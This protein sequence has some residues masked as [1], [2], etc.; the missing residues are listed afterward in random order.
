MLRTRTTEP[1]HWRANTLVLVPLGLLLMV[2]I[3]FQSA[4][5]WAAAEAPPLA[6]VASDTPLLA[7]PDPEA[8]AMAD[9]A[10]GTE[11]VLTGSATPGFLEV[12]L[13][14]ET[15]WIA[16]QDLSISNRVG[17]RLATASADTPILAAP[18][19]DADELGRVPDGGV[20]ILTGANVGS[21]VAASYEGT[22]G[23]VA[24]ADLGLPYDHDH[25]AS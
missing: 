18:M 25:P 15:G 7:A 21:F 2:G 17:I 20:V 11:V 14:G 4:I 6:V 10:A 12:T 23:W 16:A 22:G 13:D 3:A 9:V 1:R 19:P 5:S 8:A 24:E